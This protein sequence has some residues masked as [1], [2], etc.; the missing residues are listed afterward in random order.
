MPRIRPSSL[1]HSLRLG[2]LALLVLAGPGC[3]SSSQHPPASEPATTTYVVQGEVAQPGEHE[4]PGDITV[5]EAVMAAGPKQPTVNLGRVRL[6]R[7]DPRDPFVHTID[8]QD[9]LETG[10]STSNVHV[11]RGDVIDV[12]A[13]DQDVKSGSS[14]NVPR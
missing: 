6:I 8:L 5:F 4:L 1:G 12:P 2:A 7:A 10:D 3:H 14:T 9:M 13:K 11:R